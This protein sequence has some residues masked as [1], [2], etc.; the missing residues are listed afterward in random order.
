VL[1]HPTVLLELSC[2]TPA[3]PR[4]QTLGDIGLLQQ[5]HQATLQEVMDFVERECLYGLGY[6]LVDMVLLASTFMTPGAQIWTL[7]KRL[8]TL[9]GRFAVSYSADLH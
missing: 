2:G 8:A 7:D 4:V 5:A 6:G 3:Q 1:T 9:A